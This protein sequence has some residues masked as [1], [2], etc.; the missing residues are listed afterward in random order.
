MYIYTEPPRI[1]EVRRDGARVEL[2]FTKRVDPET[3]S[4]QD[5][6]RVTI[7]PETKAA[8]QQD[9]AEASPDAPRAS[10][11]GVEVDG[12]RI[13]LEIDGLQEGRMVELTVRGLRD[14][15][16]RRLFHDHEAAVQIEQRVRFRY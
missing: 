16:A 15:P 13:F 6:Y 12:S 11:I 14:V 8:D 2:R 5:R 1:A 7:V 4:E 10:V 3:A 9:I